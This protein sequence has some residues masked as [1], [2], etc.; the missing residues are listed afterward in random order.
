[1]S[2]IL[3]YGYNNSINDIVMEMHM[4]YANK[5]KT[6]K[7]IL[8]Y[9]NN[10]YLTFDNLNMTI[11]EF[12]KSIIS[13]N[14]IYM[15]Q[16]TICLLNIE[17]MDYD[18]SCAFRII[19]ERYTATT[20]FVATTIKLSGIDKPIVSR[21]SLRRVKIPIDKIYNTTPLANIR[22]KPCLDNIKKLTKQCIQ[23]ECKIVDIINDLTKIVPND[24]IHSFIVKVCEIE[25][26]Y[27]L[28][29]N[30]QI[31]IEAIL[32]TCFYSKIK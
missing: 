8:Y 17:Q 2:N 30:K 15:S 29:K 4:H 13:S 7:G 9:E 10:Y 16:R 6:Y 18:T 25:Y 32:L 14:T 26:Q 5:R 22:D 31:A 19:L 20:K 27:S 23:K 11:M 3:Y 28:H 1:M 24:D 12:I 21:F